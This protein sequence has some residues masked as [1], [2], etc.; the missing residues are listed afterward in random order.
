MK[1]FTWLAVALAVISTTIS[2][3]S[4]RAQKLE[5]SVLYRQA[6]DVAYHAVIPGYSGPNADITGACTLDP[7]PANCPS[8]STSSGEPIYTLIGTTLSL[9]LPDGRIALVNCIDRHSSKGNYINR[10][11]C[12]M[13]LGERVEVEFAGHSAKLIWTAGRDGRK[14]ESQIYKIVAMLAKPVETARVTNAEG[15]VSH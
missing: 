15:P 3:H 4:A 14:P 7:D 9:G 2:T 11:T 6:S 10:Q 13:P 8:P 12:G 5:A 1:R